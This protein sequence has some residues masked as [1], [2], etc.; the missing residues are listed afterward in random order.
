MFYRDALNGIYAFGG[1]YA[2]GVLEWSIVQI[3]VF[4]I[5]AAITGAVF[6]WIGGRVDALVGPKPVI[7][8]GVLALVCVCLLIVTT[9]RTMLA[10]VALADGS[11]LPDMAFYLCG[12]VIGAAGGALQA[13]S[14]TMMVRQA[15]PDRMTEA[16]GLYALS[17]KATSFAAPALVALV[18]DLTNNQR[19][20]VLPIVGLFVIGLVLLV[21]VK[22]EGE[23][24]QP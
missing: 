21:W 20:G 2:A 5:V 18:T 3:G 1:I 13:S 8:A 14:R 22:P 24:H 4:G 23:R 16:F 6:C 10:G 11:G 9:D 17:G 12:A 15:N 19:L 7:I